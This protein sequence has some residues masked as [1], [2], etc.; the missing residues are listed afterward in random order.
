VTIILGQS[1]N[2]KTTNLM[3]RDIA[4]ADKGLHIHHVTD[5]LASLSCKISYPLDQHLTDDINI[6]KQNIKNKQTGHVDNLKLMW[7]QMG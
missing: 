4:I 1:L 5:F 6:H 2:R 7:A 3:W